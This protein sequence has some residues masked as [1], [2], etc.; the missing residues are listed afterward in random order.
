M[1]KTVFIL[2]A[3]ASKQAGAPLMREFLD[4]ADRLWKSGQVD[5][6]KEHY[7]R[8]FRQIGKFQ[9]VHSK[10]E[11]DLDNIESVFA[12]FEMARVLRR[13]P[14]IETDKIDEHV[15]KCLESLR[16]LIVRTLE[17]TIQFRN[18]GGNF[19]SGFPFHPPDPYGEFV[20]LLYFLQREAHPNHSLAILTFN[21]DMSLDY[22]LYEKRLRYDY[23]LGE[24]P[25]YGTIPLLKLHGSLNWAKCKT[26][27]NIIPWNLNDYFK[28]HYGAG[29]LLE[30]GT[31]SLDIGTRIREEKHCGTDLLVEPFIVPPTWNKTEQHRNLTKVWQQAAKELSEAENIFV[32][33]YSLP[34]S[35]SFFQ[36]L[37]GLGAV[38]D[39]PLRRFWVVD[40]DDSENGV[41]K[42]FQ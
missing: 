33:G 18:R 11:F 2:G 24:T 3:G 23:F 20:N 42:T 34:E 8:V 27:N 6:D 16:R 39:F 9:I 13:L 1:S 29:H 31:S 28:T 40:P 38:G 21:Y 12:T 26:C 32:I 14:G 41:K 7:E 30:V 4:V 37:Y 36:Y 10:S 22:A 35:D 5:E 19:P 25:E 15:E 17:V